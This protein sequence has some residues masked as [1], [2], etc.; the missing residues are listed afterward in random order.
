M[1]AV[2]AVLDEDEGDA[3]YESLVVVTMV[4]VLAVLVEDEG[5]ANYQ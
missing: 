3:D 1:V 2:L 4:A 5:D